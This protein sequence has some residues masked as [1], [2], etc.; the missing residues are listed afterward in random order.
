MSNQQIVE[1]FL[2]CYQR[3]DHQ[4][5]QNCLDAD[6][7]FSDYAF[8]DISGRQVARM[9][10]W[11][12]IPYPPRKEPINVPDFQIIEEDGNFVRVHY[13]VQY[14]YGRRQRPV[15]YVIQARFTLENGKIVAQHDEFFNVSEYDFAKMAFGLPVAWLSLTPV[16]RLLV[17]IL[18]SIKLYRFKPPS[19][20]SMPVCGAP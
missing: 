7:R 6:V 14:G 17:R 15:D 1:Q 20:A 11:F 3:H 16:L 9:W 8:K 12:C 5:M 13:H 18:G 19:C 10:H 4:G 2:L